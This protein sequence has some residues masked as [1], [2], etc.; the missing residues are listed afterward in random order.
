[1]SIQLEKKMNTYFLALEVGEMKRMDYSFK[2]SEE[3]LF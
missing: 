2:M 1:M 3:K